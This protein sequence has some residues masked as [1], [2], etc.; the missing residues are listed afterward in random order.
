MKR[1]QTE[2]GR[3]RLNENYYIVPIEHGYGVGKL[4]NAQKRNYNFEFYTYDIQTAV[5]HFLEKLAL[6]E[7]ANGEEMT[8]AE[9]ADKLSSVFETT[10]ARFMELIEREKRECTDEQKK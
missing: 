5:K 3:I 1:K 2:K 6:E 10:L 7:V 8:L 9:C 4:S